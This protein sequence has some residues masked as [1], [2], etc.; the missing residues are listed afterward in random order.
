[1]KDWYEWTFSIQRSYGSHHLSYMLNSLLGVRFIRLVFKNQGS[2]WSFLLPSILGNAVS[3]E[4]AE[5]L[6]KA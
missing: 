2:P 5:A 1:V 6:M 4:Q 3:L